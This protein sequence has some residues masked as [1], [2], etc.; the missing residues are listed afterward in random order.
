MFLTYQVSEG[1]VFHVCVKLSLWFLHIRNGPV[2][3]QNQKCLLDLVKVSKNWWQESEICTEDS[4]DLRT[5]LLHTSFG[6]PSCNPSQATYLPPRTLSGGLCAS[7][8]ADQET[9][10]VQGLKCSAGNSSSNFSPTNLIPPLVTRLKAS[11][12]RD[13][14]GQR[15]PL[16]AC[17]MW[18][19]SLWSQECNSFPG[20]L[21]PHWWLVQDTGQSAQWIPTA[22]EL[23]PGMETPIVT[24]CFISNFIESPSVCLRKIEMFLELFLPLLCGSCVSV[25]EIHGKETIIPVFCLSE[26]ISMKHYC[27]KSCWFYASEIVKDFIIEVSK[28]KVLIIQV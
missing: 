1:L 24:C 6:Y 5:D 16:E 21:Y 3:R 26:V 22:A 13:S 17:P 9:K 12:Q 10:A 8:S 20:G 23:P 4:A 15:L 2:R 27:V 11:L 19:L 7:A 14:A 28:K 18:T 25:T